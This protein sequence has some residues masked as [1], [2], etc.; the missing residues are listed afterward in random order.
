M[1]L[2]EKK[3]G[4]YVYVLGSDGSLRES[5]PEGTEGSVKRDYETSDG[6][7]GVKFE[8]VYKSLGGKVV[9]V[10]LRD[11]DY[12]TQLQIAF[13]IGTGEPI[14]LSIATNSPYGEDVMKKLP[15]V[16]FNEHVVF[17]PYNFTDDKG[18]N[19]RGMTITQG[20]T[21]LQSYYWNDADKKASNGIPEPKGDT[22]KYTKEKWVLYFA[23]VR[24]FL[25]DET[26]D[27]TLPMFGH[28]EA[29]VAVAPENF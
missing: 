20:D 9:D 3:T 6:K 4:R 22:S 24:D 18:K 25:V 11:G 2:E 15:N 13:D 7:T 19:R 16:N 12:G 27:K 1:G 29:P 8:K 21:K 10:N 5:V 26:R 28:T 17:T 23:T 14:V